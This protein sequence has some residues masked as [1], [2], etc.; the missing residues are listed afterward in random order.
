MNAA[1][2]ARVA[3][4]AALPVHP[5]H[6]DDLAAAVAFVR[7]VQ[8]VTVPAGVEPANIVASTVL[9]MPEDVVVDRD[10]AAAHLTTDE[11]LRNSK[12]RQGPFFVVR[13][14]RATTSSS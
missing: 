3:R 13:S 11:L 14:P 9:T 12:N 6:A 2:V 4:L 8:A 7:Q 5:S 10:A 1:E